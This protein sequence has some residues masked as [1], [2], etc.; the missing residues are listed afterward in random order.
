M[1]S[2][3]QLL[4]PKAFRIAPPIWPTDVI[5]SLADSARAAG[6]SRPTAE[7][8]TFLADVGT[9]LWRLKQRMVEPGTDRPLDE[10]RRAYRHL[11]STWDA[12][13]GAGLQILDHTGMAFDAGLAIKVLAYQPTAGLTRDR[14]LET[15]KPSIYLRDTR[16]QM[17]EVIVGTPGPAAPEP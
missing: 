16:L 12:L 17:G 10:M 15:V 9:G 11:E 8:L 2:V 3:R 14:V 7:S 1:S 5:A 4:F 13:A 6:E